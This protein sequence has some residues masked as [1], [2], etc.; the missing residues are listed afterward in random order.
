MP[1]SAYTENLDSASINC[2]LLISFS[3]SPLPPPISTIHYE[4]RK[5]D[6]P[7]QCLISLLQNHN[8]N[9]APVNVA[10]RRVKNREFVVDLPF[11]AAHMLRPCRA[12]ARPPTQTY[13]NDN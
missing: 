6:K 9:P 3:L 11:R 4:Y 10:G 8:I 2:G 13:V 1:V 7:L 5:P 12:N